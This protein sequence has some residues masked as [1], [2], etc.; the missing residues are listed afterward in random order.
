MMEAGRRL[1]IV[2]EDCL[3]SPPK[4]RDDGDSGCHCDLDAFRSC[5]DGRD[6][7]LDKRQL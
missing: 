6:P 7:R 1:T 2:E 5:E 4:Y 3:R